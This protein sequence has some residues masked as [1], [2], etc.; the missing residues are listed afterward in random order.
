MVIKREEDIFGKPFSFKKILT[1][2]RKGLKRRSLILRRNR[3]KWE[4]NR[5]KKRMESSLRLRFY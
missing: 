5:I 2:L 1:H 3:L 4:L